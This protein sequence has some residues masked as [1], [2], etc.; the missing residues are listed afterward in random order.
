MN[1]GQYHVKLDVSLIVVNVSQYKN[2]TMISVSVS[3]KNP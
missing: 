2:G 1:R 3:V